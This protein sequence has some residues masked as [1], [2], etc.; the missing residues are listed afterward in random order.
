MTGLDGKVLFYLVVPRYIKVGNP[1]VA[2]IF[3]LEMFEISHISNIH[4]LYINGSSLSHFLNNL[5]PPLD[6]NGIFNVLYNCT[7]LTVS[8]SSP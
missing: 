6:S 3:V 8:P 5:L 7:V 2:N 4:Q 1:L